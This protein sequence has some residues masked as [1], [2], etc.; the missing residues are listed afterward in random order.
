MSDSDAS[1]N[2]HDPLKAVADAMEAAVQAAQDGATS[3][4]DTAARL[5]PEASSMLA[6]A[7]Y[8]TCYGISYGLV[9]PS[10]LIARS[11]PQNNP[12]VHGLV[13]GAHAARDMISEMKASKSAV[14]I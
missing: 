13:D 12:L 14:D 5:L 4:R 2:Q 11:I 10:V 8:S 3:A 7:A 6:R 9:F 1:V